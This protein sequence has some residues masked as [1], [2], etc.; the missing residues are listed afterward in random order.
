MV[1]LVV[2]AVV[3]LVAALAVVV[4]NGLVHGSR[5]RAGDEGGSGR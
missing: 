2:L 5:R 1:A 4:F 3:A